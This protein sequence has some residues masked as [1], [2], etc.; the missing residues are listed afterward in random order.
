MDEDDDE[1]EI[2]ECETTKPYIIGGERFSE[3][4]LAALLEPS[5]NEF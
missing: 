1:N 2:A 3:G 5:D 4:E